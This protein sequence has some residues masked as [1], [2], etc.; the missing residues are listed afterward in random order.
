MVLTYNAY[1]ETV[2]EKETKD[3]EIQTLKEQMRSMQEAQKKIAEFLIDPLKIMD[4][5]RKE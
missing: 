1:T 3:K 4:V 2:E 5:L